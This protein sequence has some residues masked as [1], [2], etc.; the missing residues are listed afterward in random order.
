VLA[1]GS[2]PLCPAVEQIRSPV[3]D[4]AVYEL[5]CRCSESCAG[6]SYTPILLI[7]CTIAREFQCYDYWF[8]VC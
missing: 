6:R 2:Y 1:V 3:T 8:S 5:K 7:T 4:L